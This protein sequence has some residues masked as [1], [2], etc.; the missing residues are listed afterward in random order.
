[1][2]ETVPAIF[3]TPIFESVI[4]PVNVPGTP[5]VPAVRFATSPVHAPSTVIVPDKLIVAPPEPKVVKITPGPIDKFAP[6]I[7][8]VA[9]I[10]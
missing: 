8:D 10:V 1:L 6:V 4:F 5:N 2:A 3:I 9:E 7:F